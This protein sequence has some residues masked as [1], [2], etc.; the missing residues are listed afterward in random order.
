[1]IEEELKRDRQRLIE[2]RGRLEIHRQAHSR[3][4]QLFRKL[5]STQILRRLNEK[6]WHEGL[7]ELDRLIEERR[8]E[9]RWVEKAEVQVAALT[10]SIQL[11][12]RYIQ[13]GLDREAAERREAEERTAK[14]ERER[15]ELEE[16]LER[17]RLIRMKR[18]LHR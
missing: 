12:E 3:I 2:W 6:R 10:E 11:K 17:R 5:R 14:R 13:Q 18:R 9:K 15:Q 7:D 16:K 1:M 8:V 4:D